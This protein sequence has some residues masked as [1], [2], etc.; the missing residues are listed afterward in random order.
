M[1]TCFRPR[2][3]PSG[4]WNGESGHSNLVWVD[5]DCHVFLAIHIN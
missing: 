3:D 4:G 2:K 5:V 1:L